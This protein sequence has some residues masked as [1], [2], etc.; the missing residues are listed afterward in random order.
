MTILEMAAIGL[1]IVT[2]IGAIATALA[3]YHTAKLALLEFQVTKRPIVEFVDWEFKPFQRGTREDVFQLFVRTMVKEVVGIPTE[4]RSMHHYFT[5][6]SFTTS[7][8]IRRTSSEQDLLDRVILYKDTRMHECLFELTDIPKPP[9]PGLL[10]QLTIKYQIAAVGAPY[11]E[12]WEISFMLR[13]VADE[14]GY[15]TFEAEEAASPPIWKAQ[16]RDIFQSWRGTIQKWKRKV[17]E[18]MGGAPL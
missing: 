7:P 14:S 13:C 16:K 3:A 15:A 17:D 12:S 8:F 6:I 11:C 5:Y 10:A 9:E 2:A 1:S 4:L 18:H